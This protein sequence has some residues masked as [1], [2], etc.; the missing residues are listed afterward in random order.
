MKP[1]IGIIGKYET[2]PSKNKIIYSYKEIINKIIKS[3]GIP[4]QINILNNINDIKTVI[5]NIDGII[6][7]GGDNYTK[8]EI[9][10]IKYIHQ[11]DKPLLGICLGMQTMAITF[12]GKLKKIKS[13][14]HNKT[15][16]VLINKNSKIYEILK[17]DVIKV[18]SRHKYKV[19]ETKLNITGY[20]KDNII[21]IIEDPKKIFFIGLQWHPESL[22]NDESKKIF[23]YFINISKKK[24]IN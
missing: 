18:N 24:K 11:I 7:Q 9:E 19:S 16:E 6:I 15:H 3:N 5:N 22:D 14:N 1:I 23:D 12:N 17:K 21:E 20:S 10:L 2:L 4:I 13:V 8:E